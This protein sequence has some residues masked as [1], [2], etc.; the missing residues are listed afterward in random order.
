MFGRHTYEQF[1]SFWPGA[2]QN[3]DSSG[4]HGES[5]RDP[6]FSAMAHWLNDSRK[7]VFSRSLKQVDWHASELV[8][9]LTPGAVRALKQ[10]AGKNILIFG[11]GSIVAQLSEH[12]LVDEYHF[13]VCP[14][15]LGQGRNLLADMGQHV[16]LKLLEASAFGSG[17]VLLTYQR[18]TA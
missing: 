7:L 16:S 8:D 1:A 15:L 4:P 11:S 6:A 18:D 13:V 10:Q 5:K 9:E 2:L 12:G 14:V 3:L 17:N